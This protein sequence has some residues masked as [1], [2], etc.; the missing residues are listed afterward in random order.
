LPIPDA[1]DASRS[2]A[3]PW[4]YSNERDTFG[5]VRAEYD[6]GEDL[7]GWA[8]AGMR[9]GKESASFANPTVVA[10]NGDTAA[11]RLVNVRRDRGVTAEVGMQCGFRTG[12]V[13]HRLSAS[14]AIYAL[15]SKNAFAL[16]LFG[17]IAD[18]IHAPVAIAAPAPDF[19]TGG[20]LADP[21]LTE[22]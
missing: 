3:Q 8:A 22:K 1:P 11:N 4:V 10:A 15:V 6:F 7:T 12:S 19:F 17:G 20:S 2:L 5:T 18:N 21:L 16:S 9:D 13:G 14:Y